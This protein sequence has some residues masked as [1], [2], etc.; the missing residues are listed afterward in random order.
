MTDNFTILEH[1]ADLGVEARGFSLREA[2]RNA[3]RGLMS[4]IIDLTTVDLQEEKDL[5]ISAVDSGQ[6]LVKWLSEILY[7]YDGQGFIGKEFEIHDLSP[8]ALRATVRGEKISVMKHATKLD[9]K[10]ITYHQLS[11]EENENG[12]IVRVFLDI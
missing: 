10:A 4:I 8:T 9:V 11:I 3:A 6:L 5:T 12:V 1:P 2:F 7:L